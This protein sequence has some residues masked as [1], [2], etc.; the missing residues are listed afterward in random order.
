MSRFVIDASVATKWFTEEEL[1]PQALTLR[2][3][4]DDLISVDYTL[5]EVSNALLR[6]SH[7]GFYLYASFPD[8]LDALRESMTFVASTA[9]LEAAAA[10]TNAHGSSVYDSLYVALALQESC[11]LVTADQ[12]LYNGL[13][14]VY[15]DTLLWLGDI[16]S[17]S[18]A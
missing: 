10:L 15:P 12:R 5:I 17:D 11:Q 14:S 7:R 9:L 4:N 2:D 8:D 6:K 1:R 3:R 18:P 16:Q 13:S